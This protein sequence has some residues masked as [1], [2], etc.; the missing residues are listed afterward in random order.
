[1]KP[2]N[3]DVDE[4]FIVKVQG[5]GP[6]MPLL[7]YDKTRECSFSVNMDDPAFEKVRQKVANDPTFDGRKTY[8]MA[9]F[10]EKGDCKI[11]LNYTTVKKW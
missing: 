5:G 4:R 1:M 8:M 6:I 11:Y 2:S 10:D 9:S 3:V 7:I